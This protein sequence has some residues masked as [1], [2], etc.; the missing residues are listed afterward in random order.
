MVDNEL[1]TLQ[2]RT[3]VVAM[4]LLWNQTTVEF[5]KHIILWSVLS[6]KYT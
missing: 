4:L 5:S 3:K 1:T 6:H 2:V